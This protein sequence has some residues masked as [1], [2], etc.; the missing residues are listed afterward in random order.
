MGTE[1]RVS[2]KVDTKKRIGVSDVI[3][4]LKGLR[5]EAVIKIV[6]TSDVKDNAET[7]KLR[8][9]EKEVDCGRYQYESS[10]QDE[11]N[12]LS[13]VT[14]NT[15]LPQIRELNEIATLLRSMDSSKTR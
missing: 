3:T 12:I 4:M 11:I 2:L 9:A 8:K 10:I 5:S 6:R 15:E 13:T 7:L 14:G 1:N